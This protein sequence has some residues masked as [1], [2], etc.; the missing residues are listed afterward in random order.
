MRSDKAEICFESASKLIAAAE[1]SSHVGRVFVGLLG[2][3]INGNIHEEN[4][5]VNL[6]GPGP[7]L[8]FAKQLLSRG[9]R[10]LLDQ[11]PGLKFDFFC[12]GGNH[13]RITKRTHISTNSENNLES[14]MYHHLASDF[15]DDSRARFHVAEGDMLYG[16]VFTGYKVRF[17]HGDAVSFQGGVGGLSIPM[18]KW[19]MRQNQLV[20]AE[21]TV[22]GH[23]HQL[24]ADRY[25]IT[26]GSLI[27]LNSYAQ[28]FGFDPEPPQ[29]AF[30]LIHAT[31]GRVSVSSI[32]CT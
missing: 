31:R 30:A 11:H 18:N 9:I 24:K 13:A 27:G 1:K 12:T 19:T 15:R 25:W 17:M 6:L 2:D 23:W 32:W 14:Y 8:A 21:L 4:L 29:Q 22:A 10:F 16:E 5:E 20:R 28:R 7:A 3:F 26:N